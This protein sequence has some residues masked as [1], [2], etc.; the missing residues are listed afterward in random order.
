[1]TKGKC[2]QENNSMKQKYDFFDFVKRK[3]KDESRKRIFSVCIFS[4]FADLFWLGYYA[5]RYIKYNGVRVILENSMI[6]SHVY[7]SNCLQQ[8]RFYV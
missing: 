3:I 2:L 6:N 1:M 4:L 5:H 8:E 7:D